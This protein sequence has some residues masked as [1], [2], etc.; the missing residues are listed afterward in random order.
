MRLTNRLTVLA[1]LNPDCIE[2]RYKR[3]WPQDAQPTVF[4]PDTKPGQLKL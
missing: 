2:M 1:E 3:T 4:N